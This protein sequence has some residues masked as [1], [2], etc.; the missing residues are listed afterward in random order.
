M[1]KVEPK[2]PA[3]FAT[4]LRLY[5]SSIESIS[6]ELSRIPI[7]EDWSLG[8]ARHIT[9]RLTNVELLLQNIRQQMVLQ[10]LRFDV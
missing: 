2:K 3:E 7:E 5:A 1:T 9:E 8:C 6:N 10:G 4:E